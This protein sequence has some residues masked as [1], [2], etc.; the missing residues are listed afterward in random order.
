[1]ALSDIPDDVGVRS[2]EHAFDESVAGSVQFT[3]FRGRVDDRVDA[4]PRVPLTSR[5]FFRGL[6]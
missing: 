4:S 3:G 2:R 5:S 6:R 1:M